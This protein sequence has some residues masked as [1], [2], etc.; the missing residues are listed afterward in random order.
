MATFVLIVFLWIF[1][2]CLHEFAHAIVAYRGGDLSVKDKGYLSLNPMNYLDPMNSVLLPT[3]ILILGGVG[4][5]GAAVYINQNALKN[6]QWQSA[7]SLAGPLMNLLILVVTALLIK[8]LTLENTPIGATMAFFAFLQ[9][10]AIVLNLLPLPGFDG[11]GAIEPYLPIEIRIKARQIAPYITIGFLLLIFT[12]PALSQ[13]IFTL[14]AI[15]LQLFGVS[16]LDIGV[17]Y[18][19]FKFWK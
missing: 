1:S 13:G 15:L 14:C 8:A 2:V 6:R 10:T 5:P 17:G 12:V 4:L 18:Q 9:S 19:A 7:V 11:F 3:L 16:G